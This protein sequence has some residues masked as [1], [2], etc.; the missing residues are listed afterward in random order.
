MNVFPKRIKRSNSND[1]KESIN[2][3]EQRLTALH[4][5]PQQLHDECHCCHS[6]SE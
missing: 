2:D 5:N 4:D 3:F 6:K 1:T